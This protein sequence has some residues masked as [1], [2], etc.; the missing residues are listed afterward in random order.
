MPNLLDFCIYY[1]DCMSSILQNDLMT[2][3]KTANKCPYIINEPR[4]SL[5]D[6]RATIFVMYISRIYGFSVIVITEDI[7]WAFVFGLYIASA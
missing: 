3:G 2:R 1:F 7:P 6:T 4:V 5:R